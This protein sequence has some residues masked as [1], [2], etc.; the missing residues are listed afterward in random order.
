MNRAQQSFGNPLRF[1]GG[2]SQPRDFYPLGWTVV[3][4]GVLLVVLAACG[5]GDSPASEGD[6]AKESATIQTE[7][8]PTE[9]PT[10]DDQS[11]G[12]AS[13]SLFE[14]E[15]CE[16]SLGENREV[17]VVLYNATDGP[18]WTDNENWLTDA[19]L[20][21]WAGVGA[22]SETF[23]DSLVA[24]CVLTL[25]LSDNQL[26]G[27][28]PAELGKLS[29]MFQLSLDGNQLTGE[30]PAELAELS[31]LTK[32]DLAENQ[33]TGEIPA[34]LGN[35]TDLE[36]LDVSE[37]QLSGEIPTELG[38]LTNLERVYLRGNALT[39]CVPQ[40]LLDKGDADRLDLPP[41]N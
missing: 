36:S 25:H 26:I 3:F 15:R 2:V 33:L 24:E 41:C 5:N 1:F 20:E 34:A 32:L 11:S 21:D 38:K 19:P 30:I 16:P 14:I 29:E 9:P 37:N 23:D 4:M 13:T 40:G 6:A 35:L 18:H 12:Q 7:A 27:E 8:L 39:G 22:L 28:I 31:Y 17:L 10:A